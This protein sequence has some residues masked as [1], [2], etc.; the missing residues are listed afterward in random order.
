[1]EAHDLAPF[2]PPFVAETPAMVRIAEAL[3]RVAAA[4]V[5]VLLY[6]EVGVGKGHA[7]RCIRAWSARAGGPWA[8]LSVRDP[9]AAERLAD[10][11]FGE[12]LKGGTVVLSGVDEAPPDVQVL[13]VGWLEAWA[14]GDDGQDPPVRVVATACSDLFDE[15]GQG[16]FRSDL[17]FQLDVFPIR[18]PPLRERRVEIPA[19]VE[20]FYR[21]LSPDTAFPGLDHGFLEAAQVY[22]WPG[23]LRELEAVVVAA[24]AES[25]P[26]R[27]TLPRRGARAPVLPFAQAKREFECDYV[28]SVLQLTGGNVTRASQLA[29]KARKDFYALMARSGIDPDRF[30]NE[31]RGAAAPPEGGGRTPE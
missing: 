24:A 3:H 5:R 18:L 20:H 7:S 6:G 11:S 16:R 25:G 15:V 19:L 27:A 30:R 14:T 23:N 10:P 4:D 22:P 8:H 2:D 1:M 31:G 29:G 17:Y 26:V 9:A 21:R 28:R 12:R 13:L